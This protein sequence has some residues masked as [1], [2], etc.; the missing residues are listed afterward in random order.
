MKK[1]TM[2]RIIYS[3]VIMIVISTMTM[4]Q[5]A[6]NAIQFNGNDEYMIVPHHQSLNPGDGGWTILVWIK[7]P[8]II[9]RGP[10]IGKRLP[11]E[12]YNQYTFGIGDTNAHYPTPG[13]RIYSNYIDSA[14]VSERSGYLEDEFV[15]GNWHH[16]AFVADKSV[17]SV[18]VYID[19][20]KQNFIIQY[21]FGSWPD[22]GNLDSLLIARNSSGSNFFAGEMDEL[23]IWNKAL[24]Y[25]QII[26]A[27]NDTLG[28]IYY[29]TPDSGLVGYWRFDEFEDLGIGTLGTD[30][31]RDYSYW[32]NHGG[33]EGNPLLVPSGIMV[34]VEDENAFA[35]KIFTLNQ[36]YPNPFNP[37][38]VINYQLPI[39]SWVTL[40]VYNVLGVEVATL[41]NEDKKVGR[42]NFEFR[43]SDFEISSGVYFYR[44]VAG[45]YVSTKKFLLLK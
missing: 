8:D 5:S 28:S 10:L 30:D 9:Q 45:D 37:L 17:D 41:V 32:G 27:M 42:Y 2:N 26:I 7:A 1:I 6:I 38:T 39:D 43:T 24:S 11:M 4:G 20:I 40:K 14:G 36:N 12:G 19:G 13:R 44:L 15:D 34:G 25:G 35:P 3:A 18:F 22:V 33:S 31:I 16:I 21:N 29:S 23:S